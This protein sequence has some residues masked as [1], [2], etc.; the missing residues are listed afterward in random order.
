M[1]VLS[2]TNSTFVLR[3][4]VAIAANVAQRHQRIGGGFHVNHARVLANGALDILHARSIDVS[5]F[6]SVS[7][8]HLI[9]QPRNAAI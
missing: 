8:E 3:Q 6:E 9:E 1:K 4:I 7:G 2:T 5:E